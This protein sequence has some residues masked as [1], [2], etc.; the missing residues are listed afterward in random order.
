MTIEIDDERYNALFPKEKRQQGWLPTMG[1][2]VWQRRR[3]GELY[4]AYMLAVSTDYRKC[5]F[6]DP[7]TGKQRIGV[8]FDADPSPADEARWPLV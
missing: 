7:A 8:L 3:S 2:M 4:R 1:Y 5:K 6:R